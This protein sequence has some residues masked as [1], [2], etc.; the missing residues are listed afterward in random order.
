MKKRSNLTVF[1]RL[2]GLVG[3]LRLVMLIAILFGILGF[4][5]STFMSVVGAKG[6]LLGL[7]IARN[8]GSEIASLLTDA[9]STFIIIMLV[10]GFSRGVLRYI[11]QMANH[12][13]AF[14][15][16]AQIRDRVFK[17]LRTLAPAKLE[18]RNKGE[19][20][21][22]ITSDIELLE[23][24]Y[25]HTISPVAIA[26]GMGIVMVGYIGYLNLILGACALVAYLLVGWLLPVLV[27]RLGGSDARE[28]REKV[29]RMSGYVLDSLRGLTEILQFNRGAKRLE[30][31]DRNTDTMSETEGAMKQKG[32]KA[33]SMGNVLI[34]VLDLLFLSIA[35]ILYMQ[36]VVSLEVAL[37]SFVALVSSY[38]PFLALANLGTTLQTTVASANRVLDILEETPQVQEVTGQKEIQFN[39][40]KAENVRFSYGEEETREEILKGVSVDFP[41]SH[42]IGIEGKSGSGKSTLL[43]LLMRFWE[44]NRGEVRISD[45]PINRV[46]TGNLRGMESMVAQDTQLFHDSLRSN[47]RVGRLNATDEEVEAAAKKASIHDFILSLPQ[48]Y[49]TPVGELGE[50]LSGGE[51][52]RIGLARAFLHNAPFMLLDEPTSNLDSLNEAVI[53][54]S[55]A[56]ETKE[57]TVVIVSHRASTLASADHI[58]RMENGRLVEK[59]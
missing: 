52:Q 9:L 21:F 6:I 24:F 30:E 51:R 34:V 29:S 56:E 40:A 26:I 19:L 53:L 2:I 43:R 3:S 1:R 10:L 48:G 50:T 42:F 17:V 8:G 37:L 31:L 20:I 16:L 11:E 55:I 25:A 13:I 44:V 58:Y 22:L 27:T 23:V 28:H 38:G 59:A 18:G 45:T 36:G 33:I 57:K 5:C 41:K 4:V 49:D 39:G 14:K 15:V 47:I 32:A 35:T 7:E 54:K 46:N 12:Y